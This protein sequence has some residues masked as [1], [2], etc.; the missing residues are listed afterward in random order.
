MH[1]ILTNMAIIPLLYRLIVF[2][3][4][5]VFSL[6]ASA[7]NHTIHLG[8]QQGMSNGTVN[9][10][11]QDKFG[12]VWMA[13]EGGLHCWDGFRFKVYDTENSPLTSNE[14]NVVCADSDYIYIGL[15]RN[16]LYR[17]N[18]TTGEWKVLTRQEGLLSNAVREIHPD[19][20]GGLWV[21]YY[22]RGVDYID[23]DGNITHYGNTN[24]K[25]L[26]DPNW[27]ALFDGKEKLYVGHVTHG[28][29]V[30]DIK[31]LSFTNFTD[32]VGSWIKSTEVG[33][34]CW[35]A[36]GKLWLGTSKGVYVFNPKTNECENFTPTGSTVVTLYKRRNGQM[37]VGEYDSGQFAFLE[38]RDGNLW[39][40]DG[41]NGI[42][43][44]LHEKPLFA[45]IDTVFPSY[46]F[47]GVP[48]VRDCCK[49]DGI[50]YIATIDGLWTV[51][52]NGVV[53]ER[54]DINKQ[55][56]VIYSNAVR[57]DKQGKIWLGTFGDGLYVFTKD[58]KLV[59][60][61]YYDPS[62]DINMIEIDS[63]N[64]VWV[65][66]REGLARYDNTEKPEV[67]KEYGRAQGFENAFLQAVCEGE[68]GRIWVSGNGGISCLYPDNDQIFN[69]IYSE[70]IPYHAFLERQVMK[71]P[72]GRIIFGQ[73]QGACVFNPLD[74]DK[75]SVSPHFFFSAFSVLRLISDNGNA[76]WESVPIS[77]WDKMSFP[78]DENSFKIELGVEDMAKASATE[79]QYRLKGADDKWYDVPQNR[80]IE[81]HNV[82]PGKYELQ[83][84][85]R[86][87]NSEWGQPYYFSFRVQQP[88]WWSIWMKMLY[89]AVIAALIWW[90]WKSYQHRIKFRRQLSERLAAMYAMTERTQQHNS[91]EEKKTLEK[92]EVSPIN[93][94][95]SDETSAD[96]ESTPKQN[97]KI[98]NEEDTS[99]DATVEVNDMDAD[100]AK[101]DKKEM[102]IL[103][104]DFLNRLDATILDNISEQNLDIQFLTER[105]F[106]SH[107]TLYRKIK[108]L[109]GMSINEYVRKHKITRAMHLLNEGHSVIDV[110]EKCGFNSVNYFR[111]CFKNEYGMLPSEV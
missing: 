69:Y 34:M 32:T 19:S 48:F 64:R 106:V 30:I 79:F 83:V 62:P 45:S 85:A 18:Q 56:E 28:L 31:N 6:G 92:E 65:A 81:L 99:A 15:R 37:L 38:D 55:L 66:T 93:D 86:M 39:S 67:T 59:K 54:K 14:L 36:N 75:K 33:S 13:T 107:S 21:A 98:E 40:A 57:V 5:M 78:Y 23:K 104:R 50:S 29:S 88:W 110:S 90:I 24:I 9:S 51:D 68:N 109:T 49:V 72:D 77:K 96:E 89:V 22:M 91:Q 46:S 3:S 2:F 76:E 111:R 1:Y 70:G 87:Y 41:K 35:D 102:K 52:Q 26:P 11:S 84:R 73:E 74:V 44:S 47:P 17:L 16:G 95:K 12:K 61:L 25:G 58:G 7:Q 101:K 43:V 71:L 105:M 10:F 80:I 97:E 53:S 63:K 27:C 8:L 94:A 82:S 60:H 100:E 20:K 42:N 108:T 4:L 103:D